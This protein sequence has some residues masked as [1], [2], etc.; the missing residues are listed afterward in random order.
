MAGAD[1]YVV[2]CAPGQDLAETSLG[3]KYAMLARP[4]NHFPAARTHAQEKPAWKLIIIL[5]CF[6]SL[7]GSRI[8]VSLSVEKPISNVNQRHQLNQRQARIL[9]RLLVCRANGQLIGSGEEMREYPGQWRLSFIPGAITS[10]CLAFD[11]CFRRPAKLLPTNGQNSEGFFLKAFLSCTRARRR[12]GKA[13]RGKK[14]YNC[15]LHPQPQ[16]F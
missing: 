9:C 3:R 6:P 4:S 16:P 7:F 13:A 11:G 12:N 1:V 8:A 10:T 2:D 14:T 5:G 15:Q